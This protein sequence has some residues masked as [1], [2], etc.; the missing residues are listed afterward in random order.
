MLKAALQSDC[1]REYG[2]LP[3][4]VSKC[5]NC[6]PERKLQ[7]SPRFSKENELRFS[8]LSQPTTSTGTRPTCTR[9][10]G[11][12]QPQTDL[13][14]TTRAPSR[15]SA[16]PATSPINGC[17]TLPS[18]YRTRTARLTIG[19]RSF[20]KGKRPATLPTPHTSQKQTLAPLALKPLEVAAGRKAWTPRSAR[21]HVEPADTRGPNECADGEGCGGKKSTR[22]GWQLTLWRWCTVAPALQNLLVQLVDR[23]DVPAEALHNADT[24]ACTDPIRPIAV[25]GTFKVR[26]F[27]VTQ[28]ADEKERKSRSTAH[29]S[30]HAG[31]P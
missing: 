8:K 5:L 2:K 27:A 15:D 21:Q 14:E 19:R 11:V 20:E 7:G 4:L 29:G 3:R 31:K 30:R 28:R 18:T 6:P 16:R 10:N 9:S 1:I 25:A 22:S 12:Q 24:A 17:Q 23:A 13:N 26:V